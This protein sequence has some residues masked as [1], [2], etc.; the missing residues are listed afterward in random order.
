MGRLRLAACLVLHW[1]ASEHRS[2]E[3]C[4]SAVWHDVCLLVTSNLQFPTKM[5]RVCHCCLQ[6]GCSHNSRMPYTAGEV[7]ERWAQHEVS[8]LPRAGQAL[9]LEFVN[10]FK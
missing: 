3:A 5:D 9:T 7:K 2:A 6:K 1:S 4:P 8:L 10:V